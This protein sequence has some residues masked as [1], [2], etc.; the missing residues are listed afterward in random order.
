MA[1]TVSAASVARMA[2]IRSN[3]PVS[4][5]SVSR[6]QIGFVDYRYHLISENQL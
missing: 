4:M 1:A 6:C 5:I 2:S 3:D